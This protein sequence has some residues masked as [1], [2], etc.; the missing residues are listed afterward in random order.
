MVDLNTL[1]A[2]GAS[3]DLTYAVAINDEG[4]I[5]GFGVPPDC[6]PEDY[7]LC[8]HA[9]LLI[10]CGAGEKCTNATSDAT[11]AATAVSSIAVSSIFTK[12]PAGSA[13]GTT[14][15]LDRWRNQLRQKSLSPVRRMSPSN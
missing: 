10:P 13:R 12:G 1:I 11:S 5:G 2:P 14:N 6:A 4:E 3:L 9:Y 7:E 8:G 15:P